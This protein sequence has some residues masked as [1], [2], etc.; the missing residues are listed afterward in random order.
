[1]MVVKPVVEGMDNQLSLLIKKALYI[2]R[3]MIEWD[4]MVSNPMIKVHQVS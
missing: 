4:L 2:I 3:A 1:M